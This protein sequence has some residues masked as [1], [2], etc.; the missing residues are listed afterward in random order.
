MTDDQFNALARL[1]RLR[2]GP[3][4]EAARLV[5]VEGLRTADAAQRA[6]CSRTAAANAVRRCRVGLELARQA[7]AAQQSLRGFHGST[8]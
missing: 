5:L 2:Q 8:C 4:R 7:T 6:G 3:A 1:L